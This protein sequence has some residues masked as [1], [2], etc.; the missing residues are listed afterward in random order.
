MELHYEL[1]VETDPSKAIKQLESHEFTPQ[2]LFVDAS[3]PSSRKNAKDLIKAYRLNPRNINPEIGIILSVNTLEERLELM[4]EEIHYILKRPVS[5]EAIF[6]TLSKLIRSKATIPFKVMILDDDPDICTLIKELLESVHIEVTVLNEPTNLLHH[7]RK[8][9]PN[10]LLLDITLPHYNGWE[11]LSTLRSDV[12]Y[13]DLTI[14][15][16]TG[17]NRHETIARAY[18]SGCDE[19]VLKPINPE[20]FKLK[21]SNLARRYLAKG[22]IHKIDPLTGLITKDSFAPLLTNTLK[23]TYFTPHG[24]L[25]LIQILNFKTLK[26]MFSETKI[27]E[28]LLTCTSLA[29]HHFHK[30]LLSGFAGSGQL[31]FLFQ[32]A[33]SDEIQIEVE[34]YFEEVRSRIDFKA[35]ERN[36]FE[37]NAGICIFDEATK[38]SET[39]LTSTRNA[40]RKTE[41]IPGYAVI[42]ERI[43]KTKT[44]KGAAPRII[45]ADSDEMMSDILVQAFNRQGVEAKSFL[46]GQDTLNYFANLSSLKTKNLLFIERTLP[47][48]DGI[49]IVRTVRNKFGNSIV[50][51]F[52]S[53]IATEMDIAEGYHAGAVDYITKPF[54]TK[55]LILKAKQILQLT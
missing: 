45:I 32:H 14:F 43:Q 10:L 50:P 40:L 44:S 25:L 3:F 35:D 15:I 17:D 33:Q 29:R 26:S 49:E 19:I 12:Y 2:V 21:I 16:F 37:L 8:T 4:K 27:D 6:D 36:Y 28:I 54:S 31:G 38:N 41:S 51:I 24:A 30:S 34:R 22:N 11:L 1:I 55:L 53:H 47:D 23:H 13:D 18:N 48:V 42:T 9:R 46:N 52:L 5:D 39:L 7:L 20:L